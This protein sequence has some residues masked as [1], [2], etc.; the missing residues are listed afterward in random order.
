MYEVHREKSRVYFFF[1]FVL[2]ICQFMIIFFVIAVECC[3]S[4]QTGHRIVG[5]EELYEE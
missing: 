2:L 5:E 1:F 3:T 4:L